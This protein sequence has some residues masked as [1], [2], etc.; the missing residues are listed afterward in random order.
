MPDFTKTLEVALKLLPSTRHIVVVG[1]VSPYDRANEAII[2]ERKDRSNLSMKRAGSIAQRIRFS[3]LQPP[4]K[5][6]TLSPKYLP[7][8][9][10]LRCSARCGRVYFATGFRYVG[11]RKIMTFVG[12]FQTLLSVVFV[13]VFSSA[14]VVFALGISVVQQLHFTA[15]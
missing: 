9:S 11:I 8:H 14:I 1:G 6:P 15:T 12:V 13:G 4:R 2:K 5:T 7:Q 10:Q 3:A